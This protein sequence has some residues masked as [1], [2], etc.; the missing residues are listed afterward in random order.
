[1]SDDASGRIAL[2]TGA[3]K[4]IG[5]EIARGLGRLGAIVLL[6]ARRADAGEAAAAALRDEGIDAHFVQI[7]VTDAAS[8]A[9]AAA[10][11]EREHGRLDILINNAAVS[12]NKGVP[13]SATDIAL[14]RE[15]YETNVFGLIAVTQKMLPLLKAAPAGRIVNMSS[16]LGSLALTLKLGPTA[17]EVFN[18][19]MAYNTSKTAVNAVTVQFAVE[20]AGTGIKVNAASPMLSATELS[21]GRGS[22]PAAGAVGAIRLALIGPD[23]PTGGLYGDEGQIPW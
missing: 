18:R 8:I 14:L 7:D 4:G 6:G 3:N 21:G 23:G 1:M 22:P 10:Q 19:L 20:L 11:I 2:V 9:A 12:L 17:P 13:P 5:Y 16:G 15:T